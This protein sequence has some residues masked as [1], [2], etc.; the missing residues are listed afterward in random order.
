[1]TSNVGAREIT[2]ETTLGFSSH[3]DE[4][5]SFSD[6]KEKALVELRRT[7]NPEFLNRVDEVVVF[8]ALSFAHIEKI[9]DVMLVELRERLAEKGMQFTIEEN[10][11]EF[12]IKKGYDRKY[13]ARPLR[14]TIQREIEDPLSQQL[15]RGDFGS[16]AGV[17]AAAL[18]DDKKELVFTVRGSDGELLVRDEERKVDDDSAVT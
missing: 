2:R 14:R 13:G 11:R 1:M 15:L 18:S 3:S 10:A 6:M 7:F 5:T 8:H 4:E 17:L 9:L 12:L 16:V